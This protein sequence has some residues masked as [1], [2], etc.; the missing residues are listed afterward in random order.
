MFHHPHVSV[1]FY[2]FD[3]DRCLRVAKSTEEHKFVRIGV[4]YVLLYFCVVVAVS[5]R[6]DPASVFLLRRTGAHAGQP[7]IQVRIEA[8]RRKFVFVGAVDC[9]RY[10]NRNSAFPGRHRPA[11]DITYV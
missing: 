6:R 4:G 5:L 2:L 1:D 3:P 8:K 11:R 10:V 7:Q 9:G